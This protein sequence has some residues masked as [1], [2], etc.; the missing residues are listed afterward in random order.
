MLRCWD[1]G[2]AHSHVTKWCK[3]RWFAFPFHTLALGNKDV[4]GGAGIRCEV[5]VLSGKKNG[6]IV[7]VELWSVLHS[8]Q[9]GRE[10]TCALYGA[11]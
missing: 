3:R 1:E 10:S 7:Q 6:G 5:V 4:R 11:L 8:Q 2:G 9:E